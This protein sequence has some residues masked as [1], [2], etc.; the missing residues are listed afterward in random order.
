MKFLSLT[1][2]GMK[3]SI[4]GFILT[5]AIA[6]N[7]SYGAVVLTGNIIDGGDQANV[8]LS[9][10]ATEDDINAIYYLERTDVAIVSALAVDWLTGTDSTGIVYSDGSQ[11]T[12]GTIA[13][14]TIVDSHLI[15]VDPIT[16]HVY[17]FTITFDDT[18]IG[19]IGDG[20][21]L[22][23]SDFLSKSGVQWTKT[24]DSVGRRWLV[25]EGSDTLEVSADGKMLT[26]DVSV[27][28]GE[29]GLDQI[30]VLT[31][32][33]EPSILALL[34]ATAVVFLVHRRRVW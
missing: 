3:L 13:I 24:A 14:S 23:D 27:G 1:A 9:A 18:V 7:S 2:D 29:F 5:F 33:P 8:N 28:A 31:A 6:S 15:H 10:G 4:L 34:A 19:I 12:G 26:I 11:P 21:K 25:G 32:V 20:L 16:T 30:R 17:S 22:D